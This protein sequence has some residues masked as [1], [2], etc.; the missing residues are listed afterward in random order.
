MKTLTD[1]KIAEQENVTYETQRLAEDTRKELQ[2]ATAIAD[3]QA[4][5]VDAERQVQIAEFDAKPAVKTA[6]GQALRNGNADG[7]SE[8]DDGRQRGGRRKRKPSAP[9]KPTSSS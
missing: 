3:T 1:R 4:E 7:R 2:Q 9:R 5:V 8:C 6:E